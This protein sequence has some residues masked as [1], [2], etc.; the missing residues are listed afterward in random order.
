VQTFEKPPIIR[1]IPIGDATSLYLPLLYL[2]LSFPSTVLSLP[3][4]LGP[5][6]RQGREG[7]KSVLALTLICL[8]FEIAHAIVLA[9]TIGGVWTI[10]CGFAKDNCEKLVYQ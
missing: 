2:W 3:S 1:K 10:D 7:R 6:L 8:A 4:E 5:T 9:I